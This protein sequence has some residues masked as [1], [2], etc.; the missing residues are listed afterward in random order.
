[1]SRKRK[2]NRTNDVLGRRVVVRIAPNRAA[3]RVLVD[4]HVVY[5]H[6]DGP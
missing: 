5:L 1:M 4:T 6:L 3:S 2:G